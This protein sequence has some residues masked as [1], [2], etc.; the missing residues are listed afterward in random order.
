MPSEGGSAAVDTV[1]TGVDAADTDEEAGTEG[2]AAARKKT[3]G[4]ALVENGLVKSR[5]RA[6]P[7]SPMR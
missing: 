6:T 5:K 1:D 4:F 7:R 2:G 3:E